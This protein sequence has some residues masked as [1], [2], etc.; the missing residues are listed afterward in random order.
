MSAQQFSN[1]QLFDG[2]NGEKIAQSMSD[3]IVWSPGAKI[4]L[5]LHA[6]ARPRPAS[7]GADKIVALVGESPS[8]VLTFIAMAT[9]QERE[10]LF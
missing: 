1:R 5:G 10:P 3:W 7:T 8:L 6:P 2:T 4:R 9:T